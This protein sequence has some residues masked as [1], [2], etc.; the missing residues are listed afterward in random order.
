MPGEPILSVRGEATLEVPPDLVTLV[1]TITARDP[2]RERA[3]ELLSRRNDECQALLQSYGEAVEKVATSGLAVYPELRR[4]DRKE[5]VRSYRGAI[6]LQVTVVDFSILGDLVARAA[7]N[8]LTTVEGPW[9]ELRRESP[10]RRRVRQEAARDA[11]ARAREYAEAVGARLTGLVELAD[12]GLGAQPRPELYG[13]SAASFAAGAAGGMEPER[14]SIDLEPQSQ[15]L[16]ARVEARF[17]MS[18]PEGL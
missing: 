6:R 12:E 18:P 16:H 17:T 4:G 11:I 9:W 13:R 2:H 3:L 8:E 15:Y 10:A 7:E 14:V 1:L 5:Q